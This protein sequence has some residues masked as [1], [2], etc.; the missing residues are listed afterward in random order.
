[1][2]VITISRESASEG[3]EIARHLSEKLNYKILN[4]AVMLELAARL[5]ADAQAHGS[6]GD[7]DIIEGLLEWI[8]APEVQKEKSPLSPL[9]LENSLTIRQVRDLLLTAYKHGNMI[10]IGRGSQVVLANKPDVL[11]VRIIAPVEKRAALRAAREGLSLKEAQKKLAEADKAHVD[12]VK[13]FFDVDN[14][15][16]LLYDL[17]I[18]TDKL[19]VEA[20]ADLIMLALEKLPKLI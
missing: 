16:P 17:V 5:E 10:I 1:M 15:D 9:A 6:N 12:F 7:A 14:R 11:H 13:N 3:K 8:R 18:N 4:K 19:T 2:A 20:A